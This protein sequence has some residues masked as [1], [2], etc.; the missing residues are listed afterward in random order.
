MDYQIV[1]MDP[2][3]EALRHIVEHIAA[4]NPSAAE[5]FAGLVS[6]RVRK[7]ARLPHSGSSYVRRR[8]LEI[9]EILCGKYRIFY[10]VRPRLKRIEVL[11]VWHG[12]RQEPPFGSR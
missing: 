7:L 10:R 4:D 5:R 1:W 12:A 6:E 3:E 11:A 2:A 8:G 9:R